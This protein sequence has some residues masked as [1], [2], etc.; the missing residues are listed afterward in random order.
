MRG[1]LNTDLTHSPGQ[2]SD[3]G[4]YECQI[5]TTPVLSHRVYLSVAEPVTEILGAPDIYVEEG[6]TMNLTCMVRDSPEP[7]QYIF[8][9]HNDKVGK[10]SIEAL[11]RT[12]PR[13][14]RTTLRGVV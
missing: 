1:A 8:W 14:S 2:M 5:S 4:L 12:F 3:S 10:C 6:V 13:P 11:P 9:K 7:P